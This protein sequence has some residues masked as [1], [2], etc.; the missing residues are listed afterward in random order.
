MQKGHIIGYDF[1]R[2]RHDHLKEHESGDCPPGSQ[3]ARDAVERVRRVM[4]EPKRIG[5]NLSRARFVEK[6][7]HGE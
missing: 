7:G 3:C 5:I 1:G 6:T 2:H 4:N